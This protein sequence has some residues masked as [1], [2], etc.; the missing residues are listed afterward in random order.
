[1]VK[2]EHINLVVKDINATKDFILCAFPNWVIRGEGTNEWYGTKRKWIH[3]GTEDNYITLNDMGNGENR[4]LKSL[5]PGLAHIG[6]VVDDMDSLRDRLVSNGYEIATVGA[7]HP[8]RKTIYFIDPAGFEFE[9]IEYL[10]LEPAKRNMYGGET[11]GITRIGT[12]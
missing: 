5:T 8:Y 1:M 7:N 4:D 12:R 9:F 10:S 11:G 3:I 2:L 6:F